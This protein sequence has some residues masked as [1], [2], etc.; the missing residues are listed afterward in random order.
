MKTLEIR[1]KSPQPD[2]QRYLIK[3][4][5]IKDDRLLIIYLI[6]FLFGGLDIFKN[7]KHP[8]RHDLPYRPPRRHDLP[9]NPS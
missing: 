2:S 8:W 5:L 4:W 1:S 6:Y 9:C 7:C 3:F